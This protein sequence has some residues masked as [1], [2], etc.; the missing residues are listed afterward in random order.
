[1]NKICYEDRKKVYESAIEK[2]G[3]DLQI[4]VAIEEM[5]ELQKELCKYIR[6]E[7]NLDPIAEETAD[8]TIMLEQLR[9]IFHCNTKVC[10]FMDRKVK[11]LAKRLEEE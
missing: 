11:R 4:I 8:T 7:A 2:Y 1:M 3:K 6:G 9:M 5:S 10:K